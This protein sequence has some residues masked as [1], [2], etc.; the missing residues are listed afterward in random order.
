MSVDV[1]LQTSG[2]ARFDRKVDLNEGGFDG[3][4]G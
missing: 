3:K 2:T 4:G 1:C